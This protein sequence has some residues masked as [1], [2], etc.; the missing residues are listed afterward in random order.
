MAPFHESD[1]VPGEPEE[2]DGE[3]LEELDEEEE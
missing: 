2:V 1:L 3:G